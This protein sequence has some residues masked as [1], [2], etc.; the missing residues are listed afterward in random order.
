MGAFD[1][2]SSPSSASQTGKGEDSSM[3]AEPYDYK[4]PYEPDIQA[5]LDKLRRQVFESKKFNRAELDP[6][7]PEAALELAGADGTRS[8]LD[9]S[10]I[11]ATPDFF[12]A[13]PLSPQELEQYFGTQKP[14]R[15]TVQKCFDFWEDIERGMARYIILYEGDVPKELFFVGYSFD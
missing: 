3:G 2:D 15:E 12:C 13:S 9:I 8:I 1:H 14:T 4:V 6:P 7:T 5:A 10:R 11:S